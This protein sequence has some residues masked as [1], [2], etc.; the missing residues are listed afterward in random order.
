MIQKII[1]GGQTGADQAALD[2]AIKLGIPHS[3]WIPKGRLTEGGPL[4]EKYNLKEMPTESYPERT[5]KN[6]IDSHGTLIFSHGNLT[7]G[8]AFTKEMADK[9]NRPC[10]HIDLHRTIAFDTALKI[11]D[12]IIGHKISILNVAG[13]RASKDPEIYKAVKDIL[14]VV[15]NLNTIGMNIAEP[16]TLIPSPPKTVDEAVNRLLSE[17]TLKD[18]T[19]IAK[20]EEYE[21]SSLTLN[22][23]RYILDEFRIWPGN[24]DLMNSC[25]FLLKKYDI[26]N[27]EASAAIVKELWKKLRES[28]ALRVVK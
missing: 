23:G 17:M 24:E 15:L 11:N 25:R 6:V 5:E 13:P 9:H 8:S 4:P 2:V 18:K 3:G 22:L 28:H 27:N 14:E 7:E 10:L 19:T 26:D 20:M 16:A 12:W 21:L 1:S